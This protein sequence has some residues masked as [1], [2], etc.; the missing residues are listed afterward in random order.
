MDRHIFDG[1][2]QDAAGK[3]GVGQIGDRK[4]KGKLRLIKNGVGIKPRNRRPAGEPFDK[5]IQVGVGDHHALWCAGAAGGKQDIGDVIPGNRRQGIVLP[6]LLR[7]PDAG[8]ARRSVLGQRGDAHRSFCTGLPRHSG[9]PKRR[10]MRPGRDIRPAR[11][12][13][14]HQGNHIIG[15]F[16]AVEQNGAAA[17]GQHRCQS[18]RPA[19]QLLPAESLF[20]HTAANAA[21]MGKA[22]FSQHG[23]SSRSCSG[24]MRAGSYITLEWFT[25]S[26]SLSSS[27]PSQSIL[28]R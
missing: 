19:V 25:S 22:P 12:K 24:G 8:Q 13:T 4:V 3:K 15:G 2:L 7:Q 5:M 23:C 9:D 28:S 26:N 21:P 16:G 11:P 17:P 27:L 20:P 14:A 18:S 1:K 10:Q 6:A